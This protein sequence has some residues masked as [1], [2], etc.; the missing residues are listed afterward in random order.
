MYRKS[1]FLILI[2]FCACNFF[3]WQS[4]GAQSPIDDFIITDVDGSAF[5]Q[6]NVRFRALDNT[7][8]PVSNLARDTLT[9][10]EQQEPMSIESLEKVEEGIWVHFVLDAGAGL[11]EERWRD[12]Q[13]A[14]LSFVQ[15]TPWM[16]DKLDHVAVTAVHASGARQLIDFTA[17]AN[18]IVA[19]VEGYSPPGGTNFSEPLPVVTNILNT[20][21]LLPEAEGQAKAVFLFTP[22]LENRSGHDVLLRTS[23][24]TGI[25]IYTSLV[26]ESVRIPCPPPIQNEDGTETIPV[27]DENVRNIGLESGG[28]FVHYQDVSSMSNAYRT[29]TNQRLQYDLS[30]RS[31]LNDSGTRTLELIANA[32]SPDSTAASAS[33]DV[34]VNLPRVLIDSPDEGE[35]I[36][37][38]AIAY[39]EDRGSI[40][41]TTYTIVA[42][43]IFPDNHVRRILRA[44]LLVDG[45]K[46]A[47][48]NNPNAGVELSWNLREITELGIN[49]HS[50]QV[51]VED[52][53]GMV[54]TSPPTTAK[55][56]L[57][58]PPPPP[59][60]IPTPDGPQPTLV[61]CLLPDPL[62][63]W[64]ERPIRQN[65][66]AFTSLLIALASLLF[67]SIVWFNR[68]KAP[69]RAMRE[70]VA[71]V[72]D[73]LT[74]RYQRAEARAH[75]KVIAGDINIGTALEIYGDTPI[76]R[77]RQNAELLFQQDDEDSPLSRLHCTILDEEDHFL[78]RD[79]DSANGTYLNGSRLQPLV[80]EELLDG[81]EIELARVERGGV[82]LQFLVAQ[83]ADGVAS[84]LRETVRTGQPQNDAADNGPG[85]QEDRF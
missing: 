17:D 3:T 57:I 42:E 52:E 12:A 26:R 10:L 84:G 29:V 66:I 32:D 72:V 4:V 76:G 47:E 27:C 54:S 38:A 39:T 70:T 46:K 15:T 56:E 14:M 75:L 30:Y 58:V 63:D 28:S 44:T 35:I 71:G 81:D 16:M 1:A 77:S 21:D 45:A 78:I 67:A 9:I 64:L 2:C 62:C 33:Y 40:P 23:E 50:L 34:E 31:Y 60:T 51:E 36:T 8:I 11:T 61:P 43:V 74:N 55:V 18:S 69:V 53:L 65:P 24:E 5:P 82:R 80:T 13:E 22:G 79:E 37:R 48:V 73:R 85:P 19:A 68:D 25:P 7:G 20:M 41:P 59:T 83:A 49:E 6:V